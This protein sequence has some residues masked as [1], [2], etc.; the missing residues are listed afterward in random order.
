[1]SVLVSARACAV[2]RGQARLIDPIDLEIEGGEFVL[3]IG[4]NGAGK[5]TV[6]KVLAR[7]ER[8]TYG[9]VRRRL[10][11]RVGYVPQHPRRDPT[12]PLTVANFLHISRERPSEDG[13]IATLGVAPLAAR[14]LAALSGGE[15]RRVALARALLRRPDLL[16]LDEPLA[17]IDLASQQPILSLI[18]ARVRATG[19]GL[20]LV[21]HEILTALPF[22]TRIVL[23]DRSIVADGEPVK[24]AS[25]PEFERLFGTVTTEAAIHVLATHSRRSA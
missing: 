16:L 13:I 2:R 3:L 24:V 5:S 9:E 12:L 8:P 4:P 23:L 1:L 14:P 22:A 25:S 11:L 17:G 7:L 18:D 15:L 10:R 6:V 20:L 19:A 21:A